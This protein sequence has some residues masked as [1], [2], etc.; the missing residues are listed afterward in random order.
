MT[1]EQRTHIA[2]GAIGL[3]VVVA[4]AVEYYRGLTNVQQAT[5]VLP[6]QVR[7]I[8]NSGELLR[9]SRRSS[10][11]A[12]FIPNLVLENDG[13]PAD[14]F[15]VMTSVGSTMNP[16]LIL[17]P[18]PEAMFAQSWQIPQVVEL[19]PNSERIPFEHIAGVQ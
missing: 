16:H 7:D 1:T 14:A 9:D 3:A 15:A 17:N 18:T 5:A 11:L 8:V 2:L 6:N 13:I 4:L 19:M 10:L 12:P